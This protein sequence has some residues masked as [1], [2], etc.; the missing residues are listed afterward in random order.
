MRACVR[1]YACRDERRTDAYAHTHTS[2]TCRINHRRIMRLTTAGCARN[3]VR[4]RVCRDASV[5]AAVNWQSSTKFYPRNKWSRPLVTVNSLR[6]IEFSIIGI[7]HA[8]IYLL[9][10]YL[11]S[12]STRFHTRSYT[13]NIFKVLLSANSI[14]SNLL[15]NIPICSSD[16][17]VADLP[18][19]LDS[20]GK[21]FIN[22]H[23][24]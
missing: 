18:S 20:H 9:P 24:L 16:L 2:A 6:N 15:C 13:S 17:T 5:P 19:V 11:L 3:D 10:P 23:K 22:L 8:F 12:E 1:I 14:F 7:G 4:E 21:I